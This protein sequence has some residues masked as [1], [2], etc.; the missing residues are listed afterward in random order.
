MYE[1]LLALRCDNRAAALARG[2]PAAR[3]WPNT[4]M[5]APG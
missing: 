1:Q 2:L 5:A 3:Y 4:A